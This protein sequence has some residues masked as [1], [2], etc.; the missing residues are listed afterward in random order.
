MENESLDFFIMTSSL[1]TLIDQPGQGN[2]AAAN[3]FLESFCQY[4]RKLG[5]PAS[6][7]GVCPVDDIG[8]VAENPAIR[9]KLK[10]QGL[11]FLP[12]REL[13]DYIELAV[14]NSSP[15]P[16][17][18]SGSLLEEDPTAPWKSTGHI[19]M[20]LRSE[21]HLE[22]PN[23]QA[24]WRRDRRMGMYHNVPKEAVGDASALNSNALK[25]FLSRAA[26]D[27]DILED[28]DSTDYLADEIGHRI[29]RFMMKPEEDM[30]IGLSLNALGMDSLMAIELR[31]WWKQAF[32]LDISVLEVM[33]SGTLE[34]LGKVA[35]QGLKAKF[36]EKGK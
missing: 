31:R 29:F 35:G 7:L 36:E 33:G 9:K 18:G 11:Y 21:T 1:V 6:V 4:R 17:T 26:D 28:K 13:L 14:L 24:S 22:D 3:T 2:Y 15:P 30:E 12:E 10:S 19:I 23:C 5:L 34:E 8:F 16:K 25:V 20:G 32:G 27:P